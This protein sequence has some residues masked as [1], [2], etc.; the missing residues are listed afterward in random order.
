MKKFLIL[1]TYWLLF[2]N[3]SDRSEWYIQFSD[4]HGVI[5]KCP[6]NEY[7]E[8]KEAINGFT[9]DKTTKIYMHYQFNESVYYT[10]NFEE[11]ELKTLP[12]YN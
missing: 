8:R 9:S 7:N 4:A 10:E 12:L 6:R 2:V 11:F 3:S 5:H 1:I